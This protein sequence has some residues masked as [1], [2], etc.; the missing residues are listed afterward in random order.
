[1]NNINRKVQPDTQ[2]V[3]KFAF[4]QPEVI[5]LDNGIPLYLL[6]TGTQDITKIEFLFNAGSWFEKKKLVARFTNKMLK[7]GTRSFSAAEIHETTDYYGA[8]LEASSEKDMAYVALYSLNKHLNHLLPVLREVIMEPVFP[9]KELR[10]RIQNKKQEFLINREKVKYIARW[11]FN[12]LIYGPAHPYGKFFEPDDFDVLTHQDLAEFHKNRYPVN[13]CK[14]I[15]SGKIPDELPSLLNSLFGSQIEKSS[16]INNTPIQIEPVQPHQIHIRKEKAIQTAIRIG[17]VLVNKTHPDYQKLRVVNTVLGGYFG[18]RLVTTIREKKGYTYG[19]GSGIT[20]M[21]HA[22]SFFIASELGAD[23]ARDAIA[24]IYNEIKI[25]QEEK[26]PEIE[27]NLVR[28]YMLGS[29]L[30]S[31]DGPFALSESLKGLI[32]YGLDVSYFKNFI[33]T[34]KYI[35]SEEIRELAQRYFEKDSLYE[36]AVGK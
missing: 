4:P 25:L 33:D 30:R 3:D 1:M 2:Q 8:H 9:E 19:I 15:L 23:V 7:E 31:M 32:E 29:L 17:K 27:L 20:S 24:D 21:Q 13:Q 16:T 12:E 10:T 35:T 11:K 34:I 26:V 14:I 6:N 5:R 18:S 36:I 22:G 28:N